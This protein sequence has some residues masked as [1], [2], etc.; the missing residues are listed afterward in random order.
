VNLTDAG[1]QALAAADEV[2]SAKLAEL[3]SVVSPRQAAQAVN[4]IAQWGKAMDTN[5]ARKQATSAGK[6]AAGA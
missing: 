2:V 4:G 6:P 3:L 5:K 1:R